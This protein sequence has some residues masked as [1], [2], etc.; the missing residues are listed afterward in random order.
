MFESCWAHHS[1]RLPVRFA[2]RKPLLRQANPWNRVSLP[3]HDAPSWHAIGLRFLHPIQID[4]VI[5]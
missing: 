5:S 3:R 4:V 1:I 2:N